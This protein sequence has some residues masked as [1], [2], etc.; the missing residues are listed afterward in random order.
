[1][2]KEEYYQKF[3]ELMRKKVGEEKYSKMTK[4][5]TYG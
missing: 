1:M 2:P 3:N 4:T 5:R